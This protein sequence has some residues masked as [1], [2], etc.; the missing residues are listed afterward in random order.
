MHSIFLYT[1]DDAGKINPKLRGGEVLTPVEA[2]KVERLK[3]AL[4]KLPNY[5]GSVWRVTDMDPGLLNTL[6]PGNDYTIQEFF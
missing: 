4:R 1:L 3:R 6:H 5:D 2:K